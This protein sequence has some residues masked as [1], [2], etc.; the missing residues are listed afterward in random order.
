MRA[1]VDLNGKQY[2]IEEGRYV[3]VDRLAQDEDATLELGNVL[4]VVDGE[5]TLIGA[6]F[7]DGATVR[8]RVLRHMRGPKLLVYKMRCKKGYRRKNGHRQ[9]FTQLQIE[10]VDFPGRKSQPT[11]PAEKKERPVKAAAAAPAAPETEEKPKK[12]AAPKKAATEKADKPK[13]E[14]KTTTKASAKTGESKPKAPKAKKAEA[15]APAEA[16]AEQTEE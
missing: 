6:P 13:A 7:V 11:P 3:T 14:K 10:V 15:E 2:Q 1:I 4:L 8:A 5:D 12:A 9:D 16:P